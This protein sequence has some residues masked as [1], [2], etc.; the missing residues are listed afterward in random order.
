MSAERLRVLV[1]GCSGAYVETLG[2]LLELWGCVSRE[3][4]DLS[5]LPSDADEFRP[6]FAVLD[7]EGWSHRGLV[8]ASRALR[9]SPTLDHLQV[10]GL[11]DDGPDARRTAA[12]AG[13]D[14]HLVK[15]FSP[16]A[17]AA[18]M[19]AGARVGSAE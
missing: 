6:R 16:A 7:A 4:T 8:A 13:W 15:P 14:Y 11:S 10:I 19:G 17:L 3:V 12:E 1:A 9:A 5:L 2:D 18:V